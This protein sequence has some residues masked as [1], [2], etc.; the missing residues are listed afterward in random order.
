MKI[1][2]I[3]TALTLIASTAFAEDACFTSIRDAAE[4]SLKSTEYTETLEFKSGQVTNLGGESFIVG[5]GGYTNTGSA[6]M[7]LRV[8]TPEGSESMIKGKITINEGIV[9]ESKFCVTSV[10]I[11]V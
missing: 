10:E 9:T 4:A 8:T 5:N 1:L 11:G 7:V 3:A 2:M 6:V